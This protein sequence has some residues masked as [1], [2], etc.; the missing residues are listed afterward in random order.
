MPSWM[1]AT[2][3]KADGTIERTTTPF[4]D[5]GAE[6][7]PAQAEADRLIALGYDVKIERMK[8]ERTLEGGVK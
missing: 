8:P 2:R 3:K 6:S 4:P 7:I 1:I 5:Q